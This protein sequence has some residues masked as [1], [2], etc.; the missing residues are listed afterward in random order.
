MSHVSEG[1]VK[2]GVCPKCK[3]KKVK[4]KKCPACKGMGFKVDKIY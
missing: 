4:G 3:W 2:E 1:A